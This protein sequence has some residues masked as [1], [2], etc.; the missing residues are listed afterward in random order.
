MSVLGGLLVALL[1]TLVVV[2]A[3]LAPSCTALVVG[4]F[5]DELTFHGCVANA[6]SQVRWFCEPCNN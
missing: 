5:Q 1:R 6:V 4:G 3:G 2:A